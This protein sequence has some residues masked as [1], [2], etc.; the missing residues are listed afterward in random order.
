MSNYQNGTIYKI[1]CKDAEITDC[2]VGSTTSHLKRKSQHKSRCNNKNDKEY[3]YPVYRFIR[4]NGGWDNWEFVLLEDYPCRNKKQLNI[5]E[6]FWFEKLG[7]R[8]NSIYPQRSMKEWKEEN[9]E[10]HKTHY[11]KNKEQI[12]EGH[13][14]YREEN[15]EKI[16]EQ[17]KKHY[18]EN[19]DEIDKYKK[20]WYEKNRVEILEKL[21]E[22]AKEKV[23]CP[24]G[25]IVRK[26]CLS[27]H[28]RTQKHQ[29]WEKT[30]IQ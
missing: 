23:E 11:Q 16:K 26:R 10:Y 13:K 9:K 25:S 3:N 12:L 29:N 8:L 19:K 17:R 15:K 27:A 28:K 1:V 21:N 18:E 20:E 4:D 7:A 5:R 2:Y 6:R 24:C 30:Q 14:K 22:K